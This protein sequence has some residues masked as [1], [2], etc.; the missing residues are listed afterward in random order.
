MLK[1]WQG[2]INDSPKHQRNEPYE[3]SFLSETNKISATH[4]LPPIVSPA[5]MRSNIQEVPTPLQQT[6]IMP[7]FSPAVFILNHAGI[8]NE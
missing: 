2:T 4:I 3:G 7:Q 5:S 8:P 1:H 6:V